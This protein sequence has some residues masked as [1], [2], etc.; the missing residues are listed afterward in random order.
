MSIESTKPVA[1]EAH[2]PAPQPQMDLASSIWKEASDFGQG[3][4][5]GAVEAPVNGV[6][7]LANHLSG[8]HLP[9]L[10][11]TNEN[12]NQVLKTA[13]IFSLIERPVLSLEQ[14]LSAQWVQPLRGLKSLERVALR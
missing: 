11:L 10:H 7:Q 6:V 2:K 3:V 4:F 5:H 8:A 9:E 14:P 12:C 13:N 1:V